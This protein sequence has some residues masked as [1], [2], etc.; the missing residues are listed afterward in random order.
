MGLFI[1]A[2][3]EDRACLGIDAC[4]ICIRKCPVNIF[5]KKEAL[6]TIDSENEDECTLCN[7]CIEACEP[8]CI[9]L[10]KEYE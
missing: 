5:T 1:T 9:R 4:G 7:L 3:I 8:A 6:P 2:S 10:K